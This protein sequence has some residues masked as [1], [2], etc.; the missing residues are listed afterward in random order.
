MKTKKQSW[1]NAFAVKI[2]C[3]VT[4]WKKDIHFQQRRILK[5]RRLKHNK[6]AYCVLLTDELA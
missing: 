6:Y 3:D 1:V 2:K 4:Q 5:S